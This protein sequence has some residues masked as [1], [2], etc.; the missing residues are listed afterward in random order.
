MTVIYLPLRR[1]RKNLVRYEAVNIHGMEYLEDETH[2]E[3]S[4]RISP[5]PR[6]LCS[7]LGDISDCKYSQETSNTLNSTTTHLSRLYAFLMSCSEADFETEEVTSV[8]DILGQ[9]RARLELTL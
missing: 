1:V 6:V 5:P 2:R 7:C 8:R 3:Q 4:Q 9:R